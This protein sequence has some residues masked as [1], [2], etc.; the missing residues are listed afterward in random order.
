M[1]SDKFWEEFLK[2]SIPLYVIVLSIWAGT[3]G[4]I[5]RV[6]KGE[7]PFF[8]LREWVGDISI[9]GF[10]GILT[11]FLCKYVGINEYLSAFFISISA[12][13]GAR[14]IAIFEKLW[15]EKLVQ[16][17]GITIDKELSIDTSKQNPSGS[18]REEQYRGYFDEREEDRERY[19]N[20]NQE[21]STYADRYSRKNYEKEL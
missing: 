9:S 15:V 8:S 12:H 5:R 17:T 18:Y 4:T 6:R 10:I 3:V 16:I 2:W 1:T 21:D 20:R 7:I 19:E 14:A 11:F 13:M